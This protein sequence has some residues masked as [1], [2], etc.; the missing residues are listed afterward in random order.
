MREK[1][2]QARSERGIEAKGLL[3]QGGLGRILRLGARVLLEHLRAVELARASGC[4]R[5]HDE[6][7]L[8]AT[9]VSSC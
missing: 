8:P 9:R 7:A 2:P 4:D 5:T 6:S 1:L 3:H